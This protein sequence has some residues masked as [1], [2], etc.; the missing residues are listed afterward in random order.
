[1]VPTEITLRM[2][3]NA[4]ENFHIKLAGVGAYTKLPHRHDY[5]QIYY[6]VHGSILHFANEKSTLLARGDVFIIPPGY[7]HHVEAACAD[8]LFYSL[9]FGINFFDERTLHTTYQGRF[10]SY[11]GLLD[12]DSV[13]L[14]LSIPP[15]QQLGVETAM[16]TILEEF[17][18]R[19]SGC[20]NAIQGQLSYLLTLFARLYLES[21]DAQSLLSEN[22]KQAILWCIDYLRK[23]FTE[24]ITAEEMIR[25]SA[26]SRTSFY[27]LFYQYTGA[28]FRSFQNKLRI[29]HAMALLRSQDC[30]CRQVAALCGYADATTFYRNFVHCTGLSPA[31]YR[32]GERT[33]TE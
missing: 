25:R 33:H 19:R 27:T 11:L 26:M 2:Y 18:G 17:T 29:D 9:S 3:D 13:R 28:T 6:I 30:K 21:D 24:D 16:R 15:G 23:N 32:R 8:A 1:M 10:L 7:I 20:L 5:Y 4:S 31:A 22:G 12:A 14:R